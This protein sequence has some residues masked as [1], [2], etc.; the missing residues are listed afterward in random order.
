MASSSG[1][2]ALPPAGGTYTLQAPV[3]LE[4]EAGG[5]KLTN[6]AK[7]LRRRRR[8]FLLTL[9]AVTLVAGLRAAH[10]RINHPVYQGGF[11]MLISDPVNDAG[12][13]EGDNQGD[14]ASVARNVSRVDV[15]TLIEVLK[16]GS[17]L[18][19]VYQQLSKEKSPSELPQLSVSVPIADKYTAAGVLS[20]QANGNDPAVVQR[21]LQLTEKAYLAWSL[22]QRRA[23]LTEG[24]KFL[25]EQE[26]L[27][28]TKSNAIQADLE[29]FRTTHNL[30][31]P[32]EEA[33][34]LSGDIQEQRKTLLK[35]QAERNRLIS[36][37]NDVAQGKLTT[38]SFSSDS[39]DSAGES[40][41]GTSV[42]LGVPN[43]AQLEELGRLE[44]EIA[45]AQATYQPGTPLLT[46][47][48]AARD[49]LRPQLQRKELDAIDAALQQ[50]EGSIASTRR[51]I[52]QLEGRFKTQPALLRQYEDLQRKLE[53]AEGNLANYLKTRDQFQ[54]EIAQNNVPWKVIGPAAVNPNPVAP[55]LGLGLLQGLLL[56]L[57]AGTGAA[58]LRDRLD[59]VFH[60]PGAV[61]DEL[62]EP[63]LGHIPHISFFEGV[64][65]DKRFLLKELDQN[66]SGLGG[67]QR[68][69]YQEAFRNLY[70]SIRFLSSEKPIR[71]IAMTSSVPSE[72]KSLAIVLLAKTLSELGKRVLLIDTDLRMPQIHQRLGIDNLEGL[73]NLLTEEG[74]SWRQ[75]VRSV[76]GYENWDVI[77]AGRRAPDP[78]RLLSSARMGGLVQE[79]AETGGY[80]LILYDTPPALGLADAALVAEQLDGILLLVSLNKVD[81]GLPAEAIKRI[82]AAGAPLLGLVTNARTPMQEGEHVYGYGKSTYGYGSY[83]SGEPGMD[84]ST[85][86]QY[87]RNGAETPDI[88]PDQKGLARLVPNR[89]NI[90]RW[91]RGLKKWTEG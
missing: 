6:L 17:V 8:V 39:T 4:D 44:Q 76:E 65:R 16:S 21:F 89:S 42:A 32:L 90:K 1:P 36:L 11:R 72:G 40:S 24:V 41:S 18:E 35:Q 57:V 29:R 88:D 25:D 87:Y 30:L 62:K 38:K 13:G 37:R 9:T 43:E 58:L 50:Y 7:V 33:T 14:I 2:T 22:D 61:R 70:T 60:S 3:G 26:P 79:I 74:R 83:R 12:R 69:Y 34:S 45:K 85:A 5:F 82:E 63:L 23:K 31:Q 91:G 81:R 53:I 64:R 73:T 54:L 56:G 20:V 19:P 46:N 80:D 68:F 67:Y 59:H 48:L 28:R 55:N 15:P 75:L 84:P 52:D 49:K 77:T 86:Y 47:L 66:Q 27:L 51:Q 10:E 78:P 71:S